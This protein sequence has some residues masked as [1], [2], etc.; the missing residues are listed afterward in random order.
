VR[1]RR[2]RGV[3]VIRATSVVAAGAV[4][5]LLASLGIAAR[6]PVSF[7]TVAAL[8]ETPLPNL[9]S[10]RPVDIARI[11]GAIPDRGPEGTADTVYAA[12]P[13][14]RYQ[15]S[16]VEGY[17]NCSNL[18]KGLSWGLLR[19]GHDFEVVYLFP[20]ETFLMGRGHTILRANLAL[21]EGP[22]VGL[23]D[24]AAAAIPRDAGRALDV[25]D[26][27]GSAPAVSLDPLRPE[28][29]DWTFFYTPEFLGDAVIGRSSSAETARWFRLLDAIYLDF[30]LPER[31]DKIIY[32][33]IGTVLGKLPRIHV[34]N[35]AVMSSRHPVQFAVMTAALWGMRIAP[36]VLLGCSLIWF[37]ERLRRRRRGGKVE[38][39]TLA[40]VGS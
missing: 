32:V 29:E 27:S 24:V 14:Q 19:D 25:R 36:L 6:A 4:I 40:R 35:L 10:R 20:L 34:E 13:A 33:G 12:H 31:L 16:V 38:C 18:V 3:R 17:G 1:A 7:K 28:S 22:R 26:F 23:V 8:T 30:G 9:E 11:V 5:V 15:R 21:P 2:S 39:P 37:V